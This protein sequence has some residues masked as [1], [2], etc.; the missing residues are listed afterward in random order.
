[1]K[2]YI[3]LL[4]FALIVILGC[5]KKTILDPSDQK[6]YIRL[7]IDGLRNLGSDAWYEAWIMWTEG[8]G[9]NLRNKYSSIG[10]LNEKAPLQFEKSKNVNLGYL[11]R[12]LHL[13]I[14]V[15]EDT[16]SG[17]RIVTNNNVADTL[18]GPSVYKI[19]AA[20]VIANNGTFNIGNELILDFNFDDAY[21]KYF[22]DTPTDTLNLNLKS[23]IWFAD[24]DTT[25]EEIKDTLGNVIGLDTII[26]KQNGLNLPE[27][28]DGWLYESW[29]ILNGD[30]LSMGDF[31]NPAGADNSLNYGAGLSG[32]FPFPGEDFFTNAPAG[33]N[34]PTDLSGS[35][36][37]VSIKPNHPAGSNVPFVLVPF[38]G[39]I[40]GN[41]EAQKVYSLLNNVS[42][43]P[44]GTMKITVSLYE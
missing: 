13:L 6:S 42:S 38:V 1:M 14:T 29:I 37:F 43:F 4:G 23:G 25:I 41:A 36:V 44:Q 3:L 21:G 8:E 39:T 34:F 17:F 35:D 31:S 2:N 15:E 24:L 10:L 27:L 32:G 26:T 16:V 7:E 19:I 5:E 20:K 33:L 18:A 12:M 28:P 22:L 11:Q 9:D 40:P 30:S